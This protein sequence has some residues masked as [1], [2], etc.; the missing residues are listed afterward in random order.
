MTARPLDIVLP[1]DKQISINLP[2]L[3]IDYVREY[4]AI[5]ES[6]LTYET[7]GIYEG[8]K[9][10]TTNLNLEI[11]VMDV[12]NKKIQE[13][14]EILDF[15]YDALK[16]YQLENVDLQVNPATGEQAMLDIKTA[17]DLLAKVTFID[18]SIKN[19]STHTE[20]IQM[21]TDFVP[22]EDFKVEDS[23]FFKS[24]Q[25]AQAKSMANQIYNNVNDQVLHQLHQVNLR[26]I[27]TSI[28]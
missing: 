21:M 22:R 17:F 11:Q 26:N 1:I 25:L 14:N 7:D 4:Q 9:N 24:D 15:K 23:I 27:K 13:I 19:P 2:E 6:D 10:F 16:E 5:L 3:D 28:M 12:Y 18:A 20:E 8:L